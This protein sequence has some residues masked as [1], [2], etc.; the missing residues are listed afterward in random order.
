MSVPYDVLATTCFIGVPTLIVF[1]SPSTR[2]FSK[3]TDFR[4]ENLILGAGRAGG[5]Q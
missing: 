2:T 5:Q 4:W 1:T 3:R